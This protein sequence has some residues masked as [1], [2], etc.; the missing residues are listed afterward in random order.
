[1]KWNKTSAKR[2]NLVTFSHPD[3]VISEQYRTIRTNIQFIIGEQKNSIL[4]VTS[5]SRYEGKSTTVA[6]IAV[7]MAQQKEKVLLIDANLRNP[8]IHEILKLPYSLGL[9]DVLKGFTSFEDAVVSSH[10]PGLKVLPSGEIPSNPSELLSSS[11]MKRLLE[12]VSPLYDIILIDSPA[13]LDVTDTKI[14]ANVSDGVVLVVRKGKTKAE[15]TYNAKKV[16]QY[17]KSEIIG[18][19]LNEEFK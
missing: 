1:M 12:K 11:I 2:R 19:I 13:L 6:N 17:A 10:I 15:H 14:L 9:T 3:S 7:S 8:S 18:V 5:P 16:L 4:L